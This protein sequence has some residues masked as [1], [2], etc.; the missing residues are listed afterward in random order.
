MQRFSLA[1][2]LQPEE[3]IITSW[4]LSGV[5]PHLVKCT[6]QSPHKAPMWGSNFAQAPKQSWGTQSPHIAP[7][8]FFEIFFI[9]A[10]KI[11]LD[12]R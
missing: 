10:A 7:M 11:N 5:K 1:P 6:P 3:L 8:N 2:R 12:H 4:G 9:N